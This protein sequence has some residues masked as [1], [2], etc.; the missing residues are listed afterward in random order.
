MA[1]IVEHCW[2]AALH[3]WL[4]IKTSAGTETT[5]SGSFRKMPIYKIFL[6]TYCVHLASWKITYWSCKVDVWFLEGA[7]L[8]CFTVGT[9]A[10]TMAFAGLE[11][12]EMALICSWSRKYACLWQWSFW[13]FSVSVDTTDWSPFLPWESSVKVDSGVCSCLT[14]FIPLHIESIWRHVALPYFQ[15]DIPGQK[16]LSSPEAPECL[17]WNHTYQY[18]SGK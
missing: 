10:S 15:Q 4:S 7:V 11:Y 5:F 9:D 6:V 2:L 16:T 17:L 13:D 3:K 12:W 1:W 8:I 18:E 14:C